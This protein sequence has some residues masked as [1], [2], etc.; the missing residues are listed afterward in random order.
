MYGSPQN[1]TTRFDTSK[2]RLGLSLGDI[3]QKGG[4]GAGGV[5]NFSNFQFL[6]SSKKKPPIAQYCPIDFYDL[7]QHLIFVRKLHYFKIWSQFKFRQLLAWIYIHVYCSQICPSC[8][9]SG[10]DLLGRIRLCS[11]WSILLNLSKSWK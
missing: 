10:V 9:C 5:K 6:K 7:W 2:G 4:G 11:M 3:A 1:C 8:N